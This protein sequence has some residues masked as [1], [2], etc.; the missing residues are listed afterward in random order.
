MTYRCLHFLRLA[1]L[2]LIPFLGLEPNTP[3]S[4]MLPVQKAALAA[5][6]VALLTASCKKDDDNGGSSSNTWTVNGTNYTATNVVRQSQSGFTLLSATATSGS[7]SN[8]VGFI[9]SS[10]PT[11]NGKVRIGADNG[12]DIVTASG[13][14][15]N[16]STYDDSKVDAS[17]TVNSGKISITVPDVWLYKGSGSSR[18]SVKFS[19]SNIIEP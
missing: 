6:T 16:Y 11:A 14:T 2:D 12:V 13:S 4:I 15:A 18:D 9:F 5:A 7:T 1:D 10:T 19:C 17:V 3:I 8:S